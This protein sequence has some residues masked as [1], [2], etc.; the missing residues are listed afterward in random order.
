MKISNAKNMKWL[1]ICNFS[2]VAVTITAL[3]ITLYL[4]LSVNAC[5]RHFSKLIN[6]AVGKV[7]VC[8]VD[9]HTE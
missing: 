8:F 1:I 5:A 7:T 2:C 4:F 3:V 6:I 9:L